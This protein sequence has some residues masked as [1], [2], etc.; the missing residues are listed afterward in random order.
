MRNLVDASAN[1][2]FLDCTYNDAIGILYRIAQNDYQYPI[3]RDAQAKATLR[4]IELGAISALSTLPS[5]TKNPSPRRKEHCKA[6]TLKSGKQTS[7]PTTD[8]T[9]AP[10]DTSEVIPS[11]KVEFEEFFNVNVPLVDVLVQSLNYGKFMKELLSKKKKLSDMETIALTEVISN[12]EFIDNCDSMVK[13]NNIELRHGWQIESLDLANRTAPIFQ[14]S[15]DEAPTLELKPL[16]THLK[17]VFLGDNNT[18]PVIVSV[19]LDVTKEEKLVNILKQHRRAITWS[20]ADIEALVHLFACTRSTWKMKRVCIDYRK[21]NTAT[22]KDH[23]PFPFIDQML[24]RLVGR[25]YYYFLNS[26]SWYNQIAIAP[27]DQEK[28][29]FTCPFGTFAFH[30]MPFSLCNAPATFQMYMMAIFSN[31]IEDSLEVFKDDFSVYGNDFDH[32]ANNLDKVLQ[33]CEDTHL[34]LNWEEC[35]FMATEGIMLGHRISGQ[36]IEVDKA[37]VEIIEKLPPPTNVKEAQINYTTTEKELLVVVFAFDK[38]RSYLVGTMII[39]FTDHSALRYLFVKKDAKP[40]LIH[41]ILL[42][43][44]FDIEIKDHKGSE[45]QFVDHLS[46]LD[47]G[48]EDGNI[49]QIVDAFPDE[50]LFYVDTTPWY[51]DLVNHLVCGKLPLG[52]IGR[53]KERFLRE[54][55]KYHWNESYLFNVCNDNIIR[56]CVLEDEM[57][58]ILKHSHDAPYRSHFGGMYQRTGSTSQYNEMLQQ[59]II[60]VEL[61]DVSGMDFMGPF[62]SSFG[63]LYILVAIDYILKW[64]EAVVVPKDDG[65]TV[66]KFFSQ[67]YTHPLWHTKG[68]D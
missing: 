52:V 8:S 11:E 2:H 59:P 53:T 51:V 28:T 40:R 1:G 22:R 63:N 12:D 35:H 18:L 60:K 48:S 33:R 34:V 58:S 15:I 46:R 6:I 50:K 31:M 4:V 19:T 24:D 7:E 47:V 17:H 61:F 66:L 64:V 43:Q 62:S 29:T 42:V 23:F 45:N 20:I 27:E 54:V 55:V 44:E 38:F 68:I 3:S 56:C 5:D 25:A 26:Y 9:V 37:K 49:L 57:L 41:W 67:A 13:T 10:Q 21:L 16:P 14:P 65:K 36:G 39:G 30:H 32:C